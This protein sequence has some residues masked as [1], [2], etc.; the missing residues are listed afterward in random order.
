[1]GAVA[2]SAKG[3]LIPSDGFF[4]NEMLGIKQ[5]FDDILDFGEMEVAIDAIKNMENEQAQ[6]PKFE[7]TLPSAWGGGTYEIFDTSLYMKYKKDAHLLISAFMW[8]GYILKK[9]KQVPQWIEGS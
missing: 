8:G 9:Y 5:R 6:T 7:I 1:V 2:E 3:L 4:Q